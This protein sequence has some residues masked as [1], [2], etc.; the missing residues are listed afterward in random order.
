[1]D[2]PKNMFLR[3]SPFL[4]L[5]SNFKQEKSKEVPLFTVHSPPAPLLLSLPRSLFLSSP[6]PSTPLSSPHPLSRSRD[7]S[8]FLSWPHGRPR[9][10]QSSARPVTSPSSSPPVRNE[11][12]TSAPIRLHLQAPARNQL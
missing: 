1:M 10:L 11:T 9:H 3:L 5:T 8:L 2:A 6:N 7:L 4:F 12:Q